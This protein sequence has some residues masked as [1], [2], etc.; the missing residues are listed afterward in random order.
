MHKSDSDFEIST[1]LVDECKK[2]GSRLI[3]GGHILSGNSL[4][5]FLAKDSENADQIDM[6]VSFVRDSGAKLL[7]KNIKGNPKIRLITGTYMGVTEFHALENLKNQLDIEIKVI[8]DVN[9]KLHAKSYIFRYS[10]GCSILYVGSSNISSPALQSGLEWNVRLLPPMNYELAKSARS[11][12]EKLWES[13]ISLSFEKKNYDEIRSSLNKNKAIVSNYVTDSKQ[14][15]DACQ[16]EILLK[17]SNERL[18]NKNNRNLIV[19][20]TGLGKTV[21]AAKDYKRYLESNPDS[22]FLFVVHRQEIIDKSYETFTKI[23]S[24]KKFEIYNKK[25]TKFEGRNVRVFI[26]TNSLNND[27]LYKTIDSKFFDYIVMDETHHAASKM[28]EKLLKYF[29]PDIL[30]GLTATPDRMDGQD[31]KKYYGKRITAEFSL[32]RAVNE[33]ILAPFRYVAYD[34]N[35]DLENYNPS[36]KSDKEFI[37]YLKTN[38]NFEKRL[39]LIKQIVDKV[40]SATPDEPIKCIGFCSTIEFA[41]MMA[42]SFTDLG[43]KAVAVSGESSKEERRKIPQQLSKGEINYVFVADLYNEGVDI[44]S[45]NTVLFLRPTKSLTI[46]IQQLGRGLRKSQHKT[47]LTAID[48]VG[49]YSRN[50]DMYLKKIKAMT[51]PGESDPSDQEGPKGH[52]KKIRT[53]KTQIK[54]ERFNL[55]DGCEI[56]LNGKSQELILESLERSYSRINIKTQYHQWCEE[57]GKENITLE[58]LKEEFDSYSRYYALGKTPFYKLSGK[59]DDYYYNDWKILLRISLIDSLEF[60]DA[61]ISLIDGKYEKT[62]KMT[63]FANM[64]YYTI[65]TTEDKD[66]PRID[67]WDFIESI[68]NKTYL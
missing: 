46:F 60:A 25:K 58:F 35:I 45:I 22:N 16:N 62:E 9:E 31:I 23:I 27:D 21:L 39:E 63:L 17:I 28:N 37:S 5:E 38:N 61:I 40:E 65:Y 8:L 51:D 2:D 7:I 29:E 3:T 57:F 53:I 19:A 68:S 24:D 12:F 20:A 50:Y 6:I 64:L 11:E 66:R 14:R 47:Q 33:G 26:V 36:T 43:K 49:N 48:L 55:P 59:H 32:R 44:P 52:K 41:K 4:I 15:Y 42:K 13:D 56:I 34:D 1:L 30:L 54:E 10:N 67:I 18:S